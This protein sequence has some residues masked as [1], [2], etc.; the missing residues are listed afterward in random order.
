VL[1][2]AARQRGNPVNLSRVPWQRNAVS[3]FVIANRIRNLPG[4]PQAIL[5]T[6]AKPNLRDYPVPGVDARS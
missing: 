5:R 4:K 6:R 1:R 3:G 2:H